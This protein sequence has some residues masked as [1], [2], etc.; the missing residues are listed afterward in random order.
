[1]WWSGVS[2]FRGKVLLKWSRTHEHDQAARIMRPEDVLVRAPS[3]DALPTPHHRGLEDGGAHL[4]HAEAV[5]CERR[6][7]V[8]AARGADAGDA[9]VERRRD[10]D[11]PRCRGRPVHC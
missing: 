5:V 2:N 9:L 4:P 3:F 8:A 10:T 6:K 1:M 11:D 7:E